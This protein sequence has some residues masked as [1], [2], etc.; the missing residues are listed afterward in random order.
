M[1]IACHAYTCDT[2]KYEY[3]MSGSRCK[4]GTSRCQ[5]SAASVREQNIQDPARREMRSRNQVIP[6]NRHGNII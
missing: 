3:Y 4:N 5:A 1:I 6:I 2:N